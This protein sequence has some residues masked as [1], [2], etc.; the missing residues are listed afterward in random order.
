VAGPD[1]GCPS[2]LGAIL[3]SFVPVVARRFFLDFLGPGGGT[4]YAVMMQMANKLSDT[5]EN[6]REA[7]AGLIR[8]SPHELC[9]QN[10]NIIGPVSPTRL[11]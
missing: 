6:D 5:F 8:L 10:G 3:V 9:Q 2:D 4:S 1:F 11:A 7:P